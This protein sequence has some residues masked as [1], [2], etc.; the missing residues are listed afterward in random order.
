MDGETILH[1]EYFILKRSFSTEVHNLSFTIPIFDPLP[2]QYYV[3]VIS[4]RWMGSETILPIAFRHLLL[5]EKYPAPTELLDLQPLPV[6][7]FSD[8]QFFSN[9]SN[10][11]Y[12]NAIQTQCFT[13][14][15]SDDSNILIAAPTGN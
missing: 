10:F 9:Y 4:D 11:R 13:P 7:S 12:F 3:R 15:Y 1:T 14:L 8:S 6:S 5:P 2:P